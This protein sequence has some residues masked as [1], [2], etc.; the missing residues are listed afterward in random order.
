[1]KL[2]VR[3]LTPCTQDL[4]ETAPDL[5]ISCFPFQ[6]EAIIKSLKKPNGTEGQNVK[7]GNKL[8]FLCFAPN[9]LL[10][11]TSLKATTFLAISDA[12][13]FSLDSF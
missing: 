3:H 12:D 11:V 4:R 6:T 13:S 2:D 1:M 8:G 7:R 5:E 9:C 10:A